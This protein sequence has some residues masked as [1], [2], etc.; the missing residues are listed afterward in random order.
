MSISLNF[1]Q[2]SGFG[3][4]TKVLRNI[5]H[6]DNKNSQPDNVY[7]LNP[8]KKE[9]GHK[10]RKSGAQYGTDDKDIKTRHGI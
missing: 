4:V 9:T 1:I 2:N 5:G 3:P 7:W 10:Y 6:P 8:A